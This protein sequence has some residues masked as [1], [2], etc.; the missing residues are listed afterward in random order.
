MERESGPHSVDADQ[1]GA[2]P[3][4][5]LN[6]AHL[7]SNKARTWVRDPERGGADSTPSII[8]SPLPANE[9]TNTDREDS[10]RNREFLSPT[11]V[12]APPNREASGD[13]RYTDYKR[14]LLLSA[15]G[16]RSR[17]AIV[18]PADTD[19][20]GKSDSTLDSENKSP[21][22][23]KDKINDDTVKSDKNSVEKEESQIQRGLN[24]KGN[25]SSEPDSKDKLE[26]EIEKKPDYSDEKLQ[27]SPDDYNSKT[28]NPNA[29]P[30]ETDKQLKES[31]SGVNG[32]LSGPGDTSQGQN[33]STESSIRPDDTRE[34]EQNKNNSKPNQD[35]VNTGDTEKYPKDSGVDH[36]QSQSGGKKDASRPN[37]NQQDKADNLGQTNN[38]ADHPQQG[39]LD[40]AGGSNSEQSPERGDKTERNKHNG[41]S[42]TSDKPGQQ[43]P[44]SGKNTRGPPSESDTGRKGF[45]SDLPNKGANSQSGTD[46]TQNPNSISQ[47]PDVTL[48]SPDEK[49]DLI[50]EGT[51]VREKPVSDKNKPTSK[52][53]TNKPDSENIDGSDSHKH[54]LTKSNQKPVAFVID[55]ADQDSRDKSIQSRDR[56]NKSAKQQPNRNKSPA[57]KQ[58]AQKKSE[59]IYIDSGASPKPNR[60]ISPSDRKSK[61]DTTR[62]RSSRS[63][64]PKVYPKHVHV[65]R[66]RDVAGTRKRESVR[67]RSRSRSKTPTS[68]S[69][70]NLRSPVDSPR[71]QS[72]SKDTNKQGKEYSPE[73]G[74][75]GVYRQGGNLR[76][77]SRSSPEYSFPNKQGRPSKHVDF[78]NGQNRPH[79]VYHSVDTSTQ[80]L[81]AIT[82]YD[83]LL[84]PQ[85]DERDRKTLFSRPRQISPER[86]SPI[87]ILTDRS[88]FHKMASNPSRAETS[89]RDAWP[90]DATT[91][92]ASP[93]SKSRSD[94][95]GELTNMASDFMERLR[96]LE[97]ENKT[98]GTENQLLRQEKEDLLQQFH[99]AKRD[100]DTLRKKVYDANVEK[101]DRIRDLEA[102]RDALK[103]KLDNEAAD[104]RKENRNL[105]EKVKYLDTVN[106]REHSDRNDDNTKLENIIRS[107]QEENDELRSDLNKSRTETLSTLKDLDNARKE[108]VRVIK[109]SE[110]LKRE[111]E[112]LDQELKATRAESLRTLRELDAVRKVHDKTEAENDRLAVQFSM[113]ETD[114][115]KVIRDSK[116]SKT[117]TAQKMTEI[118]SLKQK[119]ESQEAHIRNAN[120][121]VREK[122][123]IIESLTRE[124]HDLKQSNGSLLKDLSVAQGDKMTLQV[125][126]SQ[127]QDIQNAHKKLLEENKR[128]QATVIRR[129]VETGRAPETEQLKKDLQDSTNRLINANRRV[130]MLEEW[131]DDIY[132]MDEPE[133]HQPPPPQ[134]SYPTYRSDYS[135]V[136]RIETPSP[137]PELGRITAPPKSSLDNMVKRYT[138]KN[139][140][141]RRRYKRYGMINH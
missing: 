133:A 81:L 113:L 9:A 5:R 13:F 117:E 99:G 52:D 56:T 101:A 45:H 98:I 92:T 2:T 43:S 42:D 65:D 12:N 34:G 16:I 22:Q 80:T 129:N 14:T 30:S 40:I 15:T 86:Y 8:T 6:P 24:N 115:E 44:Q 71:N 79:R 125:V 27:N 134:T 69:D 95:N 23:N 50:V 120:D 31:N 57:A 18:P 48:T 94:K 127:Y 64:S 7:S 83:A 75:G 84:Y 41:R 118:V 96:H 49:V 105:Q 89:P 10:S 107:L 73:A 25:P 76:E 39:N 37:H 124:I 108:I 91:A 36:N 100:C 26:S 21:S 11:S 121:Q 141:G 126:D 87:S 122:E 38:E 116:A 20:P 114:M 93:R 62:P 4:D 61:L 136:E 29:N 103:L 82:D 140:D 19:V 63:K 104:L 3:S 46:K 67:S 35:N 123:T 130:K 132:N 128:L 59:Y 32:N 88:Y 139:L 77:D 135:R 102:D 17:P 97:D 90:N 60:T 58:K 138:L 68:W 74:R 111:I 112:R 106:Q 70:E 85:I 55:V 66:G 131:M 119:L 109:P 110:E 1:S 28:A 54:G 137:L 78:Q 53:K 47:N 72:H 51:K 33:K